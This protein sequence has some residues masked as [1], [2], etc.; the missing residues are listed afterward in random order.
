MYRRLR[1]AGGLL[2]LLVVYGLIAT[3]CGDDDARWA[4]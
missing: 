4:T 1:F 3:A 2:T